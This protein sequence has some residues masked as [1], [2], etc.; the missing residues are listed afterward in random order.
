VPD[1]WLILHARHFSLLLAEGH[2]NSRLF[3]AM[4]RRIAALPAPAG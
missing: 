3:G 4:V 1:G 2:W